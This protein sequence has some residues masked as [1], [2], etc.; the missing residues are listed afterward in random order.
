MRAHLQSVGRAF[1]RWLE[2]GGGRPET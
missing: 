2:V 1:V